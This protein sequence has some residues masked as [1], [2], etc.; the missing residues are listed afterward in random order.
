MT[1]ATGPTI[2]ETRSPEGASE[3][4]KLMFERLIEM[5][6]SHATY[7]PAMSRAVMQGAPIVLNYH[8]HTGE[9]T[10]C[11]SI[12]TKMGFPVAF[13]EDM[14]GGLEELVHVREFGRTEQE[15]VPLTSQLS[16]ELQGHYKLSAAPELFLNGKPLPAS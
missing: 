15:C 2:P 14:D 7:G 12:C 8:T 3:E 10:Y 5:I 13:F 16:A 9:S 4:P 1:S 6:E 11:V